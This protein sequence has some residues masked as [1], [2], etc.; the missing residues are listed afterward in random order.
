M[1]NL[2]KLYGGRYNPSEVAECEI[3]EVE[4][5]EEDDDD[6]QSA[7]HG[8]DEDEDSKSGKRKSWFSRMRR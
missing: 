2:Q 5:E 7:H 6:D 1:W 4:E 8:G 3:D